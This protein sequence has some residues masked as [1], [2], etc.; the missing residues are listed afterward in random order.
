MKS[1]ITRF[2]LGLTLGNPNPAAPLSRANNCESAK[3]A[4]VPKKSRRLSA[5]DSEFLVSG[6]MGIGNEVEC[7]AASTGLRYEQEFVTIQE[8]AD[9]RGQTLLARKLGQFA[10][11]L[12]GRSAN[13]QES[14]EVFH[15]SFQ[16]I[17]FLLQP[18]G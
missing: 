16:R 14:N 8:E 12:R 17:R 6:T 5:I 15:L 4:K 7:N 10:R 2:T 3:P 13:P 18:F 9:Q 1:W 11:F